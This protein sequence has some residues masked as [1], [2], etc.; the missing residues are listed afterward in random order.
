MD[1]MSRLLGIAI[2]PAEKPG[3]SDCTKRQGKHTEYGF[4]YHRAVLQSK[5]LDAQ[6]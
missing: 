5:T 6:L 4:L 3:A 2:F 1:E